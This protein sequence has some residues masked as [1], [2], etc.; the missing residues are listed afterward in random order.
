[1]VMQW[2]RR[3]QR[4][5]PVTV[6]CLLGML[7]GQAVLAQVNNAVVEVLAQDSAQLPLPGVSVKL[8]QPT[9]GFERVVVTDENGKVRI[10]AVPPGEYQLTLDLSG[11]VTVTESLAL[12]VGQTLRVNATMRQAAATEQVTVTAQAP[13][14][15]IVKTDSSSNIVP[16]QIQSLPV[17][18]RDF[19]KLAFITPGVERER[20]GF[21]FIGGGP[22]IGAGGNASQSTIMVDGV[23]FTDPSLGLARTRF[24][25]DAIREFRVV[26]NRF[27]TEIGGSA[28]GALSIVTRTGTNLLTGTAFAYYRA[29]SLRAKGALEQENLPYDRGQYGFT[30]GGSIVKDKT[31]FFLSGEYVSEDN[32][33][34]FRPGGA[35][36]SLAADIKHPFNQTLLFGSID[37]SISDSQ[38][39]VGKVVYEKY[40]EQNFRV[41]GVADE[42]WG[43]QLNRDNWNVTIE[44]TLVPS[45]SFLNELRADRVVRSVLLPGSAPAIFSGLRVAMGV[46]LIIIVGTEFLASND[47][48]GAFIWRSYQIFDFPSMYSGVVAVT[49]LG[50]LINSTL[51]AVEWTCIPWRR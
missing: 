13:L 3:Q 47:G 48:L 32:I 31:H 50:V 30:L 49:I 14:V 27:D 45:V 17:P 29:D 33:L 26:A 11:F 1:M 9:T 38:R 2:L 28:G 21:R 10:A 22:V 44:H 25:Q 39:L 16:E 8:A 37:H 41:G 43:Q 18:D 12:R 19:Q 46:A 24:S 35:Y 15:D 42:S 5:L 6:A 40:R 7:A 36:A 20:G 23:D 34:L 4:R 51:V